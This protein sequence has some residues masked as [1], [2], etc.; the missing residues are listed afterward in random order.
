MPPVQES[1]G[2]MLSRIPTEQGGVNSADNS[3]YRPSGGEIVCYT[4]HIMC[5]V[6]DF[7]SETSR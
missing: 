1:P 5:A 6:R 3:P 2:H 4:D 7:S